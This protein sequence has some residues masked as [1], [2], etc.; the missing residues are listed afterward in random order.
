MEVNEHQENYQTGWISL[1]RSIKNHWIFED[2]KYLKWWIIILFEVNHK[3]NKFTRNYEVYEIQKGQSTNSL[4]TWS[5]MFKT[6][7]KTVSKFFK[8]LEKDNMLKLQKI[9]KGKQALTLITVN[10]YKQYQDQ[11]KQTLLQLVNKKETRSKQTLPTNNNDNNDN[12]VNNIPTL[13]E[14][15]EFGRYRK[16][17]VDLQDLTLKYESWKA[18]GWNDGND[19]PITNWQAKLINT[20]RYIKEDNSKKNNNRVINRNDFFT[21]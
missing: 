6:T 5:E 17:N 13:K 20:L 10:N 21:D 7:P 12:N 15:L 16:K 8:L 19:K 9:G 4:R 18:N 2:E 11:S 1:Y 14:F 3:P